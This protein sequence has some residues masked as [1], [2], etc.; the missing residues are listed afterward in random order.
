MFVVYIISYF[1]LAVIVL[2][3]SY[4]Y[5]E[6]IYGRDT[7]GRGNEYCTLETI[8]YT[9]EQYPFERHEQICNIMIIIIIVTW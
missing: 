4:I 7:Y 3:V 8:R 9:T 1:V 2:I 6:V 5:K